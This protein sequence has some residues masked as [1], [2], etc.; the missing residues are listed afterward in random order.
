MGRCLIILLIWSH[1]SGVEFF[2]MVHQNILLS[3]FLS[4][5]FKQI[6]FQNRLSSYELKTPDS[7]SLILCPLFLF[8]NVGKFYQT[9]FNQMTFLIN[10][11]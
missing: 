1:H 2:M 11:C 3:Q 9:V 10:N 4:G 8:T 7:V 6:F 5:R